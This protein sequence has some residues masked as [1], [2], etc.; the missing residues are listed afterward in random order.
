MLKNVPPYRLGSN[1]DTDTSFAEVWGI[2]VFK[3]SV[4]GKMFVS[5]M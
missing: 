3:A 5:K 2:I 4:Q 1:E